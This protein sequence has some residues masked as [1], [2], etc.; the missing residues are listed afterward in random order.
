MTEYHDRAS[1]PPRAQFDRALGQP[2]TELQATAREILTELGYVWVGDLSGWEVVPVVRD[3]AAGAPLQLDLRH[4]CGWAQRQPF[5]GIT[6]D[7]A[8][9][10][11]NIIERLM[12]A[13]PGH[14]CTPLEPSQEHRERVARWTAA[15]GLTPTG[16]VATDQLGIV[17]ALASGAV[18]LPDEET[19]ARRIFGDEA[20][21][22]L[23][24]RGR[25]VDGP[26]CTPASVPER[27]ET[28]AEG[29]TVWGP[30]VVPQADTGD[31]VAAGSLYADKCAEC[32]TGA[33]CEDARR[34]LFEG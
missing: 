10:V 24:E 7:G 33:S 34:C 11:A 20:T 28:D 5:E 3:E 12:E 8:A 15:A 2:E 27:W 22:Q 16:D 32:T 26:G 18:Q 23:L 4:R 14:A 30:D 13:V 17:R 31:P 1:G 6:G 9:Y 21:E 19:L 25:L 29:K